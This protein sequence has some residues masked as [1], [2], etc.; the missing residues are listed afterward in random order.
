[1]SELP[2]PKPRY[3]ETRKRPDGSPFYVWNNRHAKTTGLICE[4]L[5]SDQAAAFARADQLNA[6]WDEMRNTSPELGPTG[7]QLDLMAAAFERARRRAK[8]RRIVYALTPEQEAL[9]TERSAGRCELSGTPFAYSKNRKVRNPFVASL[10]RIESS[11]GYTFENVRLVCLAVNIALNQWGLEC[12]LLIA[13]GLLGN[14]QARRTPMAQP[15]Q[16][17]VQAKSKQC[18]TL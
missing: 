8:D 6:S 18:P 9:I 14:W 12:L 15:V 13:S 17:S 10:D 4:S 2:K 3:V 11:G 16:V 1:M 7:R 5:G